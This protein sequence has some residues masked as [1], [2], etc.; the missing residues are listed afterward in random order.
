[1]VLTKVGDEWDPNFEYLELASP[2]TAR[3]SNV[4]I[5]TVRLSG[6]GSGESVVHIQ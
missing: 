3:L 4:V 6:A 5:S 1:M 2:Q